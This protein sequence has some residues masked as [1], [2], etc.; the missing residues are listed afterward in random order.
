MSLISLECRDCGNKTFYRT[1]GQLHSDPPWDI[2]GC[3]E[4]KSA[5]AINCRWVYDHDGDTVVYDER[6]TV[7]AEGKPFH[8]TDKEGREWSMGESPGFPP[9]TYEEYAEYRKPDKSGPAVGSYE[10]FQI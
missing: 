1:G 6:G 4:C 10:A 7:R 8:F 9:R 3:K 5:W 2:F